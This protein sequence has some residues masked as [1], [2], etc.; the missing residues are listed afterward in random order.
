MNDCLLNQFVKISFTR[1]GVICKPKPINMAVKHKVFYGL[2][3][4][5]KKGQN[6]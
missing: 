6:G 3:L 4:Q 2:F 1:T 5:K